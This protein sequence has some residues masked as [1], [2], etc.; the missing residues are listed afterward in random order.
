MKSFIKV[1]D[2]IEN[3][4]AMVFFAISIL[5]MFIEVLAR[6]FFYFSMFW[7]EEIV[8][9][10]MI[11]SMVFGGSLVARSKKHVAVKVFVNTLSKD[12][13]QIIG[14]AQNII[15]LAFT[16]IVLYSGYNLVSD[17]LGTGNVSES[18]L[19]IPM[20][21]VYLIMPIGGVVLSGSWIFRLFTDALPKGWYKR[22]FTLGLVVGLVVVFL[23]MFNAPSPLIAMVI[24]LAAFLFIGVP[25]SHAM[26]MTGCL[27]VIFFNL[28]VNTTI[29][30]RLFYS[31]SKYPLLAIPFFI[32]A[33]VILSKSVMGVYLLE[34][35]S[36][37]MK[38]S[39]AGMGIAVMV[40]SMI[41]AA[42]SGSSV[43]NA[44]ALGL[45]CIPMLVKHGY[46]KGFA[47]AI[48]GTGGSL[49]VLIPPSINLVLFG[50]IAGTSITNLFKAG[51]VPGVILGIMLCVFIYIVARK[52]KW[53]QKDPNA[54]IIW[55]DVGKQFVKSIWALLMPVIILG[56]IYTGIATPT[57]AAAVAI[58][59]SLIV[60]LLIY[61]DIK[62]R[63]VVSMLKESVHMSASIYFIIMASGLFAFIIAKEQLPQAAMNYVVSSNMGPILFLVLLNVILLVC[64]C[65]LGSAAIIVML[66]PIV[67][68]IA[69]QLGIDPVHLGIIFTIN[70]EIGFLTPPVGT[71]LYVLTSITD[72]SFENVVKSVL[73]FVGVLIIGLIMMTYIPG[74]SMLALGW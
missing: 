13:Q 20:W 21:I 7:A 17:I 60:C 25:V 10:S 30:Q 64:G 44:A 16:I 6:N 55:G 11:W 61:K 59:Y 27:V 35:I 43:A 66:V 1:W 57:E 15:A 31:M 9:F 18:R 58:V 67:A 74:I 68:P 49:A 45:L 40:V 65:F 70:L 28:A 62:P 34:M 4:V 63:E 3:W 69:T 42:M 72:L 47:A 29:S 37:M 73:P 48:L 24:G 22:K 38:K 32:M 12:N 46:P 56:S 52:N 14:A 8:I 39:N 33:G 41:F 5:V 54:V 23:L 71:N 53:D 2:M 51:I 50:A 26:G 36:S 19:S